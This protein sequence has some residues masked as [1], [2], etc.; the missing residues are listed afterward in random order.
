MQSSQN[1][2]ATVLVPYNMSPYPVS[3]WYGKHNSGGGRTSYFFFVWSRLLLV[4]LLQIM[5]GWGGR[6]SSSSISSPS[7]LLVQGQTTSSLDPS[8]CSTAGAQVICTHSQRFESVDTTTSMPITTTVETRFTCDL[9]SMAPTN[10][11]LEGCQCSA[12]VSKEEPGTNGG[13]NNLCG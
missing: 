2:T 10:N 4:L 1:T 13:G 12:T 8:N 11:N 9:S 5:G 7:P 6:R 3:S